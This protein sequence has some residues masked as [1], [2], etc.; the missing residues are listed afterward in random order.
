MASPKRSWAP[1]PP[2][3]EH[4]VEVLQ[5]V[6]TEDVPRLTGGLPRVVAEI[7][8]D[9][10]ADPLIGE[11]CDPEHVEI[12]LRDCRKV[13]FD[14]SGY[15]RADEERPRGWRPEWRLVYRLEAGEVTVVAVVAISQRRAMLAYRLAKR[16]LDKRD[17]ASPASRR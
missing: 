8:R 2:Q 13:R 11:E 15:F 6:R 17:G 9:L 12:P 14:E 3:H 7:V 1:T 16:R 5:Q 4:G 10:Y